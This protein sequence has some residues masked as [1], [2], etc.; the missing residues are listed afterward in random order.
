MRLGL[1]F[2]LI[3]AACGAPGQAPDVDGS[4]SGNPGLAIVWNSEGTLPGVISPSVT[5]SSATF[6][7]RDIRL[8][9]DASA[10]N[11]TTLNAV[12]V[13]WT[14]AGVPAPILFPDAPPGLY[15]KVSFELDGKLL[16]DSYVIT[17]TA[18]VAGQTYPFKIHDV[19]EIEVSQPISA[20]LMPGGHTDVL[21]VLDL[22]TP[23][24]GLDFSMFRN[25]GGTLVLDNA[26]S[27]LGVFR[28][29]LRTAFTAPPPP[30]Q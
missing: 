29:Q 26:S 27:Q 9:G 30:P 20:E 6:N 10:S 14:A 23:L 25:D 4:V 24:M 13:A 16:A 5:V 22:A 11:R 8:I 2:L 28:E 19:D 7:A 12:E 15:S 17:G 18:V 21:V 1:A 3:T